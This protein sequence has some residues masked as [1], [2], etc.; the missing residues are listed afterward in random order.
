MANVF[1]LLKNMSLLKNAIRWIITNDVIWNKVDQDQK[2]HIF[3]VKG[4]HR[5]NL[6]RTAQSW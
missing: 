4:S 2:L 3:V 5:Q 6:D 1:L